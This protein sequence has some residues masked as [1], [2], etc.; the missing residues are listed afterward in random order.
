M[1]DMIWEN[2]SPDEKKALL[3]W[4]QKEMLDA[5]LERKAISQD[6]Y[7]KSL[8]DMTEKMGM[9]M[10]NKLYITFAPDEQLMAILKD[11]LSSD[12]MHVEF[13]KAINEELSKRESSAEVN[14]AFEKFKARVNWN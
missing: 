9:S 11:E 13:I 7:T 12:E 2:L 1:L 3:F 4:K 6:Q 8:S 5:F 10:D 14:K